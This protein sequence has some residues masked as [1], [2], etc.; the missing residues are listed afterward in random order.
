VVDNTPPSPNTRREILRYTAAGLATGLAGCA[1]P[2]VK[3]PTL[4]EARVDVEGIEYEHDDPEYEV[5]EAN[6]QQVTLGD[7]DVYENKLIDL[8]TGNDFLIIVNGADVVIRNIGFKGLFTGRQFLISIEHASGE[9]L[10]ENV[11]LG[12]GANKDGESFVHGPGAVFY[13][14][15]AN[16]DMTFRNV[17]V[18]GFP[19]N[20]FYCSNTASGGSVTFDTCFG[21]NNGVSTFRCAS[22]DDRIVNCVAYNDDTD[23][24]TDYASYGGY[25]ETDGRP[26][27]AWSPGR[28]TI[29]DSHFAAGTYDHALSLYHGGEIEFVSGAYSG[30][31]KDE[32]GS[33]TVHEDVGRNPNLSVPSGVPRSAEEAAATGLEEES[34]EEPVEDPWTQ[35][36]GADHIYVIENHGDDEFD[37][38]LEVH[39]GGMGAIDYA[40]AEIYPGRMWSRGDRAAGRIGPGEIHCWGFDGKIIDISLTSRE[41][42]VVRNTESQSNLDDYPLTDVEHDWKDFDELRG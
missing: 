3:H 37:Y 22:P 8:T 18:Q 14:K 32:R 26:V 39:E 41:S 13:H 6:G 9:L 12:D 21:K 38:F 42:V 15:K 31:L 5:V 35:Q 7:G 25:T 23:Y 33:A 11:Y 16:C 40:D 29:E 30:N 27:W 10:V 1:A 34:R 28:V 2:K 20:G 19:N 17:N 4:V 36:Y 24:S